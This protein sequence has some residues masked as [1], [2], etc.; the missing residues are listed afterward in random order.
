[1][2]AYSDIKPGLYWATAKSFAEIDKDFDETGKFSFEFLAQISGTSPFFKVQL[3]DRIKW[4]IENPDD[5]I[6]KF[7][8]L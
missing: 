1:M 2:I 5:K 8:H 6:L 7:E 4:S 3:F